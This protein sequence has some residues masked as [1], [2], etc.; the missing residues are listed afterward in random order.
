MDSLCANFF[1]PYYLFIYC[2]KCF[3]YWSI[4]RWM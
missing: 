4:K 3:I 1:P 2:D